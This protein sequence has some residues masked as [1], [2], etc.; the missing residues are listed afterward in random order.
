MFFELLRLSVGSTDT[1]SHVPSGDEWRALYEESRRQSVT[2]V[3][4]NGVGIARTSGLAVNLSKDLFHEWMGLALQIQEGNMN[5]KK[6]CSEVTRIITEEGWPSC[7]LKGQSVARYYGPVLSTLRQSGDIDIWVY[8][9]P[10]DVIRWAKDKHGGGVFDYHH[11]NVPFFYDIK[12]EAH[13]RPTFS[14]N[15]VRNHRIQ[16]FSGRYSG[17]SIHIRDLGFS[18]APTA[19][20]AVLLTNHIFNHLL[21]EGVGMRQVMDMYFFLLQAEGINKDEISKDLSWLKLGRICSAIMWIMKEVFL[22]DDDKLLCLPDEKEGRFLIEEII[23]SGNMGQ[24]DSRNK[25]FKSDSRPVLFFAWVRRGTRFLR[26]YPSDALWNP[27]GIIWI[28]IWRRIKTL[29]V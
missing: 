29:Y 2:G 15:P 21:Y 19:F 7:I 4:F 14:R 9:E 12:V 11:I 27:I 28:S 26:H 23:R 16:K 10:L 3:C 5:V 8:G 25:H 1:L 6:K 13:Y 24:H 18:V 17:Q 20:D 22:L